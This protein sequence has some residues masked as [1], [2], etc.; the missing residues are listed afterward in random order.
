M[1]KSTWTALQKSK[2]ESATAVYEKS[3]TVA[4]NPAAS[5][6]EHV[7]KK[8]KR[9]HELVHANGAAWEMKYGGAGAALDG[10]KDVFRHANQ[11]LSGLPLVQHAF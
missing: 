10:A 5:L 7:E 1:A 9:A 4:A 11:V 6:R 2:A 8:V 3:S